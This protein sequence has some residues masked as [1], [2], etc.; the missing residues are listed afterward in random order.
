[1]AFLR[2]R[3]TEREKESEEREYIATWVV[4]DPLAS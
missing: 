1:M 3:E 4:V 2:E